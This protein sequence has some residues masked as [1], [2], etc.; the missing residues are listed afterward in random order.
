MK[1]TYIQPSLMA[2]EMGTQ[3]TLLANSLSLNSQV[4]DEDDVLVR[5]SGDWGD[6]WDNDEE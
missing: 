5:G 2:L 4:V 1:K 6:I 3:Q